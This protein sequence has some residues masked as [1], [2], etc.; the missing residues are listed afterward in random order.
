MSFLYPL[1]QQPYQAVSLCTPLELILQS[2]LGR[3]W[4][5]APVFKTHSL[6][7]LQLPPALHRWHVGF[8][9]AL[10]AFCLRWEWKCIWKISSFSPWG[11]AAH[12]P[13]LRQEPSWLPLFD[14][15][16]RE[17][18]DQLIWTFSSCCQSKLL[19]SMEGWSLLI[20]KGS[21]WFE[22][23]GVS[24][25]SDQ[26]AKGK[27]FQSWLKT[28]LRFLKRNYDLS[29]KLWLAQC[30]CLEK[31]A[32]WKGSTQV[33]ERDIF[34]LLGYDIAFWQCSKIFYG[35]SFTR[36]PVL[37]TSSLWRGTK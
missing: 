19:P 22:T 28:S 17:S 20:P 26:F 27:S 34:L 25:C 11:L 21:S 37:L 8:C 13:A 6:Q 2:G 4:A 7:H 1:N 5:L 30:L 36:A 10:T 31:R 23:R 14:S 9:F 12:I 3:Y 35:C 32:F 29:R 33:F 16:E 24:R 18:P 15:R